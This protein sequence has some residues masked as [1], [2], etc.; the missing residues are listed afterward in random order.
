M[1]YNYLRKLQPN[2]TVYVE[3][4]LLCLPIVMLYVCGNIAVMFNSLDVI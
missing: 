4:L 1:L 2:G 3:A